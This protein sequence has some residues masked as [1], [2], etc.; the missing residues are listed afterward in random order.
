MA[1]G[2]VCAVVGQ[3]AHSFVA[4]LG[5]HALLLNPTRAKIEAFLDWAWD[6]FGGS[7]VDL[8]LDRPEQVAVKWH[9]DEEVELLRETS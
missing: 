9:A 4:W 5:I 3:V 1:E 2:I 6:Y 8:V 7:N